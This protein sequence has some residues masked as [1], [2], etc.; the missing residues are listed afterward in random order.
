MPDRHD[1]DP[2]P[3]TYL[4][5][6]F[7][8]RRI[9]VAVGQSQTASASPLEVVIRNGDRHWQRIEHLL[10]PW[11]PHALIVGVPLTESGEVQEM[12]R[13]ARRFGRQLAGRYGLPVFEAD[14]RLTSRMAQERFRDHRRSGS[15]RR[16]DA[17]REDA[18]A[19]QIILEQW[20]NDNAARS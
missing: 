3:Q 13:A 17:D 15:A 5:F 11:Q 14:E 18:I 7:G 10:H 19:A 1:A 20:L 2:T 8:L 9:G 12:T 6:D 4:C 16:S